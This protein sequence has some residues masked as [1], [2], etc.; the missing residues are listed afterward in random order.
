MSGIF[1][2]FAPKITKNK[3]LWENRKVE[4]DWLRSRS[5]NCCRTSSSI[6]PTR[7]SR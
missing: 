3:E 5:A 2:I 7:H 1:C 4:N 6:I